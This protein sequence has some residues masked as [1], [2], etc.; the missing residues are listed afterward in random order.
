MVYE[1]LS[2]KTTHHQLVTPKKAVE[3]DVHPGNDVYGQIE[4]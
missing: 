4:I 2:L 1:S 3:Y